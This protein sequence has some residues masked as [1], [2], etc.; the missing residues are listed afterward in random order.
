V[1]PVGQAAG[2]RHEV[3]LRRLAD[4]P[5]ARTITRPGAGLL[6]GGSLRI[7]LGAPFLIAGAL[8]SVYDVG[9]LMLFRNVPLQPNRRLA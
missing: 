7:G 1:R 4:S 6:A 2:P 3:S 8:K 9:L 5:S